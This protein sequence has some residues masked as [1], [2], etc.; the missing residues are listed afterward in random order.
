MKTKCRNI[1]LQLDNA[2][3]KQADDNRRRLVPL[4]ETAKFFGR[5]EIALRGTDDAG[6]LGLNEP[7]TN[8][9]NF[10][11]LLRLRMKCG[12]AD[13]KGHVETAPHS[14]N[15]NLHGMSIYLSALLS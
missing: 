10:R 2:V 1:V 6:P 9:G 14:Y 7:A 3:K 4:I 8:D 15:R 13:L 11:A 12:D 5:Q